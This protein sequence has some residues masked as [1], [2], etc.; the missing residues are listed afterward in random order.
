MG[1]TATIERI[2]MPSWLP[3]CDWLTTE[4]IKRG[5]SITGLPYEFGDDAGAILS[6]GHGIIGVSLRLSLSRAGDDLFH[7]LTFAWD[8]VQG[9]AL[10]PDTLLA[11]SSNLGMANDFAMTIHDK[12]KDGL[13]PDEPSPVTDTTTPP[14]PEPKA[15]SVYTRAGSHFRVNAIR[16]D[17]DGY[18]VTFFS[19]TTSPVAVFKLDEVLAFSTAEACECLN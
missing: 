1:E 4:A 5:F 14:A 16:Y 3:F 17:N 2:A 11:L 15:F 8:G 7:C 9:V 13:A 10:A 19:G 18:L 12:L 6:I